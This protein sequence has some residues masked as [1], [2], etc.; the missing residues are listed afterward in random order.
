MTYRQLTAGD[1][2]MLSAL[3]RQGLS[4]AAIARQLGFHAST[5]G[6]ELVPVNATRT[7]SHTRP[8]CTHSPRVNTPR[9]TGTAG[10]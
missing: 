1:R 4:N 6:R 9:A 10:A 3:R 5:I 7:Q 8:Q 2:Y